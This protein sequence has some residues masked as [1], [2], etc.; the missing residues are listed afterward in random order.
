MLTGQLSTLVDAGIPI[1]RCLYTLQHQAIDPVLRDTWK[2]VHNKVSGGISLSAACGQMPKIFKPFYIAMLK[3]GE[4]TGQLDVALSQLSVSLEKTQQIQMKVSSALVYPAFVLGLTTVLTT[5]VFVTVIPGFVDIFRSMGMKLPLPTRLLIF[6]AD[7]LVN[8]G[9]WLVVVAIGLQL[10]LLQRKF[11]K[12]KKMQAQVYKVL[13]SVNVLG[14]LLKKGA[15]C[16]FA[17]AMHTLLSCGLRLDRSLVVAGDAAA[18]PAFSERVREA[19]DQ[20]S[21]GGS[22]STHMLAHPDTYPPLLAQMVATGEETASLDVMFHRASKSLE[23]DLDNQV[24]A[25]SVAIEPILLALVASIVAFI[26]V[27]IFLPLYGTLDSF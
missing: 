11:A 18:N 20:I 9:F 6:F 17:T 14:P 19:V 24:Q 27:A 8:P 13:M 21:Q 15:A 4:T 25:L 10:G 16:T 7:S 1:E 23:E 5:L 26:V 3:T 2:T 12:S 22:L